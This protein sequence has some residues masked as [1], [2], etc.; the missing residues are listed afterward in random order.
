METLAA[1]VDRLMRQQN[2]SPKELAKRCGLTDSYIIRIRNGTADN[3]TVETIVKLAN[4]LEVNPHELFARAAGV[5]ACEDVPVDTLLLLD[6]MQRVAA[7]PPSV[8]LVR[9]VMGLT[10]NERQT[11]MAYLTAN[12]RP[13]GKPESST[14]PM[15]CRVHPG[16]LDK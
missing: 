13:E 7:D 11:L 2:I 8:E 15:A 9:Q 6:T 16:Q 10:P 14:R 3:L 12:N 1:Y 5:S 4:G